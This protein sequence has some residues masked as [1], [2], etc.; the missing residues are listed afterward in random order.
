M[1]VT[2]MRAEFSSYLATQYF[3]GVRPRREGVR[4]SLSWPGRVPERGQRTA[5]WGHE[6]M[7]QI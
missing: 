5:G 6:Q 3:K 2:P 1:M 7:L 4:R